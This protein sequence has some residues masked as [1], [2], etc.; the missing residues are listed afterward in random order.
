MRCADCKFFKTDDCKVNPEGENCSSAEIFA[1]FKSAVSD[2]VKESF[3][4]TRREK[5]GS[6]ILWIGIVVLFIGLMCLAPAMGAQDVSEGIVAVIIFYVGTVT[7]GILTVIGAILFLAGW[8]EGKR[9]RA[10][11]R[12]TYDSQSEYS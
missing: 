10:P 3:P 9:R 5:M 11:D 7:G 8:N 2:D 1:C 12:E 4:K 6:I